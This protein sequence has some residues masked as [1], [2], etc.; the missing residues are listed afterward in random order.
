MIRSEIKT[1]EEEI[2]EK[3]EEQ[4][5]LDSM[6]ERTRRTYLRNLNRKADGEGDDDEDGEDDD[7]DDEDNDDEDELTPSRGSAAAHR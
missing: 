7:E 3:N 1:K 6:R 4:Q 5:L 2:A